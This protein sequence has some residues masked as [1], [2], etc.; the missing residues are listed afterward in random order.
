METPADPGGRAP[1]VPLVGTYSGRL[2]LAVVIY[3]AWLAET[4]L[5]GNGISRAPSLSPLDWA[6]PVVVAGIFIGCIVSALFL[7]TSMAR[8]MVSPGQAG[9]DPGRKTIP[10]LLI[11]GIA[12]G[13]LLAVVPFAHITVSDPLGTM[14]FL[15]PLAAGEVMVCW[16]LLA[17]HIESFLLIRGSRGPVALAGLLA[18]ALASSLPYL[19]GMLPGEGF[20]FATLVIL[21]G[22]GTGFVFLVFRDIYATLLFRLVLLAI[23]TGIS[24]TAAW[25]GISLLFALPLALAAAVILVAAGAAFS[26]WYGE[27]KPQGA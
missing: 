10:A 26:R 17:T 25:G 18:A 27:G 11:T 3:V 16:A 1:G 21:A 9:L 19:T 12:G 15:F 8:G 23:L 7:K 20:S 2:I 4:L 6:V 13:I 24:G 22:I 5:L 14:L